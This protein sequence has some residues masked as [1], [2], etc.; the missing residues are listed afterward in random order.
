VLN[1][2]FAV[3]YDVRGNA[4]NQKGIYD[5]AVADHSEAIRREPGEPW[6]HVN[7]ALDWLRK[8]EFEQSL[9]DL[10]E[11]IR[12]DPKIAEFRDR[13]GDVYFKSG[14]LDLAIADFT[15]ALKL[16][17]TR[18]LS[19]MQ[20]G[21]VWIKEKQYDKAIADFNKALKLD[22]DNAYYLV[23]RGI[24]YR[25]NR[26]FSKAL[27]DFASAT[28]MD[29]SLSAALA[30]SAWIWS[31]CPDARFR[32]GKKAVAA[33]T[34]ACE[35]SQW[36]HPYDLSVLAAAHAETDNFGEAVKWQSKAIEMM[37]DNDPLRVEHQRRLAAFQKQL[38][39][40]FEAGV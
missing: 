36:K 37:G 22:P 23:D 25:H 30:H 9:A 5:R 40:R 20:R 34:K 38:P 32:D 2:D 29:P 7:R 27:D 18:H 14:A 39:Y 13:R 11:A 19:L 24:A 8:G 17:P 10:T 3:T 12:L 28:R 16:E 26:D 31:A 6:F 21:L 15:E 35:L 4:W 1:P 33:A